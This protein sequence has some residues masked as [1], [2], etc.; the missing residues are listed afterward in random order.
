MTFARYT[1][2]MAF[3]R[4]ISSNDPNDPNDSNASNCLHFSNSLTIKEIPPPTF[5]RGGHCAYYLFQLCKDSTYILNNKEK[6]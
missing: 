4:K 3:N 5:G 2:L 1:R 6:R